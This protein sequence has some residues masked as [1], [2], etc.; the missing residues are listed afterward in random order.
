[1][2][3]TEPSRD[4]L[5]WGTLHR[6][7]IV[8]AALELARTDGLQAVTIRRVAQAV[9][10]SRMALYRHVRDK[11]DLLNLIADE[12][13]RLSAELPVDESAAWDVQLHAIATSLRMHLSANPAFAEFLVVHSAH[14]PG[15]VRMAELITR[16]VASTGLPPD[17]VAHYCLVFTDIVL[18][19][20]HREIAGDPTAASRN[21]RLLDAAQEVPEAG[22][23]R[24]YDAQLRRVRAGDVFEA[25][26]AMVIAAVRSE[27]DRQDDAAR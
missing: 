15:G 18:G 5:E 19:R 22:Y 2:D 27:V 20:I 11:A 24:R 7:R 4:A 1:M 21:A 23:V 17:R 14:G 3:R 26:V 13:S 16:A 6:Q 8:D 10:A 12:I 9:G 25:E